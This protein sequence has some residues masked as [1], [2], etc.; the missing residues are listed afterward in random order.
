MY[1]DDV[2]RSVQAALDVLDSIYQDWQCQVNTGSDNAEEIALC[3]TGCYGSAT[4]AVLRR[5][6][7][8]CGYNAYEDSVKGTNGACVALDTAQPQDA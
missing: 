6:W 7:D 5:A 2:D 4:V 1:Y 8:L 3:A